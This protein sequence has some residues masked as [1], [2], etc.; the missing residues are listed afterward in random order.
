MVLAESVRWNFRVH[1]YPAIRWLLLSC[2][3]S[4]ACPDQAVWIFRSVIEIFNSVKH[5]YQYAEGLIRS[6]IP[7][8][9]INI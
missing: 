9:T 6:D 4:V 7:V 5:N 3:G 8:Y 2:F 1:L